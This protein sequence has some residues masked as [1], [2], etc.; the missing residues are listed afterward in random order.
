MTRKSTWSNVFIYIPTCMYYDT[1][2]F[3]RIH[4]TLDNVQNKETITYVVP[5][6]DNMLL[7]DDTLVGS[8]HS[9]MKNMLNLSQELQHNKWHDLMLK[10]NNTKW[11]SAFFTFYSNIWHGMC[12]IYTGLYFVDLAH[13]HRVFTLV[14]KTNI[15]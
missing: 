5:H 13:P 12:E 10:R 14:N 8:R 2:I 4:H 15:T 6:L 9:H 7:D 3:L 11:V 1:V